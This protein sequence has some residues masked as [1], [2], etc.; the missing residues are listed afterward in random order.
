MLRGSWAFVKGLFR[1]RMT[2]SRNHHAQ[3]EGASLLL[4][5]WN[6]SELHELMCMDLSRNA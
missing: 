2:T 4:V 6:V 3:A 5:G 1:K